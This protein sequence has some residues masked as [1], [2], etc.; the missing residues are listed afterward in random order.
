MKLYK[1]RGYLT[2]EEIIDTFP[3]SEYDSEKLAQISN[4]FSDNEV[5]II[6]IEDAESMSL[7]D[8]GNDKSQNIEEE[9]D[10]DDKDEE[11]GANEEKGD[12]PV[13]IYLKE[14]G[15]VGL[16]SKEGEV[17]IAKRIEEAR[18]RLYNAL[19]STQM[20]SD[21]IKV[22]IDTILQEENK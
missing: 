8:E 17:A 9:D 5:N 22:V 6:S 1:K 3:S 4:Y 2:N 21:A 20:T 14:M 10:N 18:M 19:C 13:K 7:D 15:V 11:E 16:L 12:D